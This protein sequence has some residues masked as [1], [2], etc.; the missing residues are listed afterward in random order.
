MLHNFTQEGG[1]K[2]LLSIKDEITMD[3][4]LQTPTSQTRRGFRHEPFK[5]FWKHS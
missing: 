4:A 2:F 5:P 1:L 3:M